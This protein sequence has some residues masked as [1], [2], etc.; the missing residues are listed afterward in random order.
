[1][2]ASVRSRKCSSTYSFALRRPVPC[3]EHPA[4][5][6]RQTTKRFP[7][8]TSNSVLPGFP[9]RRRRPQSLASHF[10]S[11]GRASTGP[12]VPWRTWRSTPKNRDGSLRAP[13]ATF[14]Q[15]WKVYWPP[16][17]SPAICS[18]MIGAVV[19]ALT[20]VGTRVSVRGWHRVRGDHKGLGVLVPRVHGEVRRQRLRHIPGGPPT[21]MTLTTAW[22]QPKSPWKTRPPA[23]CHHRRVQ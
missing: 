1:M 15:T 2:A 6:S 7:A 23:Q 14:A 12:S 4:F 22:Q 21:H 18:W 10:Q 17:T 5:R 16:E 20:L 13:V 3:R 11:L 9:R 8:P 19:L